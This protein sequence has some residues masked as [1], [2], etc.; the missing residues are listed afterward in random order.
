MTSYRAMMLF[1]SG[2]RAGNFLRFATFEEAAASGNE[3]LDR[4]TMP[5]RCDVDVTDDPVNYRW[6]FEIGRAVPL[7][8]VEAV[9]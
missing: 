5:V 6:D 3:S 7:E 2:E 9:A 8:I 4:W 1:P